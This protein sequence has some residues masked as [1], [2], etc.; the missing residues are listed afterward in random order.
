MKR[1]LN[2][3]LWVWQAP[4]HLLALLIWGVLRLS[5]WLA[6]PYSSPFRKEITVVWVEHFGLSLGDYIFVGTKN[7]EGKTIPHENGHT[8]Q[9]RYLGP[10]YLIIIGLPS[11]IGNIYSRIYHKDSAWYYSQPWESWADRL[12]GVVRT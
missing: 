6:K 1:L 7:L 12:G 10:L 2:Y 3:L 4:Q 11:L 5:G 9:S 8:I